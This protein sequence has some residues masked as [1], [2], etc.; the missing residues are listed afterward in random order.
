MRDRG[1]W[2]RRDGSSI[3][4]SGRARCGSC[5]DREVDRAGR[6]G[7]GD[8]RGHAGQ[9]GE[10]GPRDSRRGRCAGSWPRTSGRSWPGCGGRTPSWRWSVMS[11]SDPWSCGS[12]RRRAGERGRVHRCPEDRAR[13]AARGG[14]PGAGGVRVVV[15]QVARPAADAPRRRGVSGW[16]RRSGR[17]STT[18]AAP[19]ARPRIG[20]SCARRAGGCRRTRSRSSMAELGLAGREPKRAGGPDPPGQDGRAAPD[21][22]KRTFTAPAP[23]VPGA[24]T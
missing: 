4:S 20:T 15:L 12:R 22:V 11:S 13:R 17:C 16:R 2:L 5:G 6:P 9:L 24:A 14:L 10:A 7:P 19:T 3:R 1:S 23:D 18:R 21:L 8:Q